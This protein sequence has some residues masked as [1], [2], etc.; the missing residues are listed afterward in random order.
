MH[1]EP[2]DLRRAWGVLHRPQAPPLRWEQR[3]LMLS[4][5]FP[6]RSSAWVHALEARLEAL[7]HEA[8]LRARAP[9]EEAFSLAAR[10]PLVSVDGHPRFA[11]G[12]CAW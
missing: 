5:L 11:A 2:C 12:S 7:R 4:G 9:G 6:G 3:I 10:A 8:A 1:V